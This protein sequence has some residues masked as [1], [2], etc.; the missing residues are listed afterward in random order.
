[1]SDPLEGLNRG[2]YAF[3]TAADK[4]IL[5]P[6]ASAYHAVLPD[7]AERSVGRF[8][9][10]LGEP[11]NIVNNLLQGKIDGA[12]HST[13]RFAVNSTIGLFGLF[14]IAGAYK[15]DEK[16]EDFGQTL[17]N[18][19]VKPGP[20]IMLPF[21]GPTNFR[22]GFGQVVDSVA[23]YPTNEITEST[24][25]RFGLFALRTIDN[26]V[27][28][29]GA[30]ETLDNQLDPYLFLKNAYQSNRIN[31]IYDGNPPEDAEDDFDF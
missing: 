27:G 22:D 1:L 21:L 25:G 20:Y 12:L 19:G 30:D 16:P 7:P 18:W 9:K 31:A 23:F 13:Y 11:L 24:Q 4:A 29:F 14:D 26:R 6:V 5:K 10:N 3:N 17:A 15:V 28:L 2:V 8:F